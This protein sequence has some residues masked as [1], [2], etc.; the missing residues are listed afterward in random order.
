MLY[1]QTLT[2]H[3]VSPSPPG[4]RDARNWLIRVTQQPAG[5]WRIRWDGMLLDAAGKWTWDHEIY[6]SDVHRWMHADE[7]AALELARAAAPELTV[8]GRTFAEWEAHWADRARGA[9]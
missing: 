1:E 2:E 3:R 6:T 4:H 7:A 8:N 5:G 9:S